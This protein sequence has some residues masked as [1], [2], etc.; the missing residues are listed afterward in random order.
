[1]KPPK[2]RD[3]ALLHAP[4]PKLTTRRKSYIVPSFGQTPTGILK[5]FQRG[6][7]KLVK[8]HEKAFWNLAAILGR[9]DDELL[10]R[11]EWQ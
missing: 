9:V 5:N 10:R 11:G 1:M 6:L 4:I 2:K 3:G 8:H 7:R